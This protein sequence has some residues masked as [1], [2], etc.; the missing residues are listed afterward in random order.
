[1]PWTPPHR[2]G[3]SLL[4]ALILALT[5]FR[6]LQNQTPISDP[7][8]HTAPRSHELPGKLDPNT[9]SAPDLAALP[10]L[11]PI[12]AQR[13]VE[14]RES[15][16]QSN[17]SRPPYEQPKDLLRVPG[18]GETMLENLSPSLTFPQSDAPASPDC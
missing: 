7:A 1:M 8:P 15:F 11:G 10:S 9:A 16:R 12:L 3:L 4:T 6:L 17:P 13:I 14:E 2:L 18:I 5:T